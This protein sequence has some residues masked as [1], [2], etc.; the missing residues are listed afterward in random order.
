MDPIYKPL[1]NEEKENLAARGL[2]EWEYFGLSKYND[3][4]SN[5]C[6]EI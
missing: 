1:T 6:K 4:D 5:L 2:K 3:P